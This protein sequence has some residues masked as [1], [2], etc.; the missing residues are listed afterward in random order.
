MGKKILNIIGDVF[1]GLIVLMAIAGIIYGLSSR[2]NN[3]V[4]KIFGKSAFAVPTSSMDIS[5]KEAEANGYNKKTLI[6]KGDVVFGDLTVSYED[7]QVG[8]VIFFKGNLVQNDPNQY[9]IV[10]RIIDVAL[11]EDGK[12]VAFITRGDNPQIPEDDVQT[13]RKGDYIAKL[14]GKMSGAGYIVLF[15]TSNSWIEYTKAD[16]T[17]NAFLKG[18]YNF[19]LPIGFGVLIIIPI[20]VYLIVMIVKLVS[21]ISNNKKVDA[22]QEIANGGVVSDDVKDAIIQEYMRKQEEL[23]KA[24]EAQQAKEAETKEAEVEEESKKEE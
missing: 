15:L 24:Q 12:I 20:F 14:S 19:K 22:A 2:Q 10:H 13:V 1:L 16:G 18:L 3:G 4:P 5:K 9:I 7:L 21:V 8:D 11:D 6:H 23:K 17:E